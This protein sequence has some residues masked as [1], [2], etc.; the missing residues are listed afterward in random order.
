MSKLVDSNASEIV[1]S[2]EEYLEAI[3]KILAQLDDKKRERQEFNKLQI[4][5]PLQGT[6]KRIA[7]TLLK[8]A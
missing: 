4:G 7:E 2:Q 3:N 6:S 1:K 5:K 8:W